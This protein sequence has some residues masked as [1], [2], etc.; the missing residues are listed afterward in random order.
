EEEEEEEEGDAD[1]DSDDDD[2]DDDRDEDEDQE[3]KAKKIEDASPEKE[4]APSADQVKGKL[5]PTNKGKKDITTY[6]V[7]KEKTPKINN[8]YFSGKDAKRDE[9]PPKFKVEDVQYVSHDLSYEGDS[10]LSEIQVC[11]VRTNSGKPIWVPMDDYIQLKDKYVKQQS[12][13]EDEWDD[14]IVN[15]EDMNRQN[16]DVGRYI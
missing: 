5:Q 6:G 10:L 2:D 12:E 7:T 15:E 11:Q 14:G 8:G 16:A 4:Q 3:E 1:A 13:K 9:Q